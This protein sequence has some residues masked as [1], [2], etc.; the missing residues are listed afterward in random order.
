M[1]GWMRKILLGINNL[2]VDKD[3]N[4]DVDFKINLESRVDFE[5]KC[6]RSLTL[7]AA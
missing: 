3:F 6:E 7:N 5:V 1:T 2:D 4:L